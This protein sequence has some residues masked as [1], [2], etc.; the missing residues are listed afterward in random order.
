VTEQLSLTGDPIVT[1]DNGQRLGAAQQAVL[2]ELRELGRLDDDEAGAILHERRGKHARDE[3][4]AWCAR[5]GR[6]VLKSL[7]GH[8]LAKEKRGNGW[9]DPQA[10]ARR[11]DPP[12]SHAAAESVGDLRESQRAVLATFLEHGP[13]HDELLIAR[14]GQQPPQSES[15]LRTRR[16]ELFNLDLLRATGGIAKTSY[17]RD[18]AVWEL[19]AQGRAE[20]QR[21]QGEVVDPLDAIGF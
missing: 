16:C 1:A 20:A 12:T 19:T 6:D 10:R 21:A 7:R 11:S 14:Y 13:M 4:C 5:D 9:V 8:K 2:E 18:T 3:R 17:G 15:G